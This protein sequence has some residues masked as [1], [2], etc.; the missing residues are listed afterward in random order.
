[1]S[2]EL[3]GLWRI[4]TPKGV[5]KKKSRKKQQKEHEGLNLWS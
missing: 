3:K 5:P 4:A 2:A 1:M